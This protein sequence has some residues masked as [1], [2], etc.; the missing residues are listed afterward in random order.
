M[1]TES[2]AKFQL[3]VKDLSDRY[4]CGLSRHWID[5]EGYHWIDYGSHRTLLKYKEGSEIIGK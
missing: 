5:E 2:Y 4:N 3:M 1:N